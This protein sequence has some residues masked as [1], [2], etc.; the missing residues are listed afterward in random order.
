M[1]SQSPFPSLPKPAVT[2]IG[3]ASTAV[4][5]AADTGTARGSAGERSAGSLRPETLRAVDAARQK[6]VAPRLRSQET[7]EQTDRTFADKDGPTGPPP[8]FEESALARIRRRAL[9]PPELAPNLP[10]DT[11]PAK[12]PGHKRP[13]HD[14]LPLLLL[15][16]IAKTT[17]SDTSDFETRAEPPTVDISR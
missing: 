6:T 13:P 2:G 3:A 16:G 9:E 12:E 10:P 17:F 8:A 4:R 5:V 11:R 15:A 14:A 1:F 7:T